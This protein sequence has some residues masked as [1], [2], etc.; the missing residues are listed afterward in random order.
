MSKIWNYFINI[1]TFKNGV[2]RFVTTT[3]KQKKTW[4]WT[5]KTLKMTYLWQIFNTNLNKIVQFFY[6]YILL[7]KLKNIPRIFSKKQSHEGAPMAPINPFAPGDLNIFKDI[8]LLFCY[9]LKI[10]LLNSTSLLTFCNGTCT[11]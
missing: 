3:F 6:K 8:M 9:F 5:W 11:F 1:W 2:K 7:K 4:K 10:S